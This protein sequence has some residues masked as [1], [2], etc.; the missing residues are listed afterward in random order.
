MFKKALWRFV[1]SYLIIFVVPLLI[2]IGAYFNVKQ[3]ML[4]S[5]YR[6]NKTTLNQLKDKMENEVMKP[7]ESLADWI[8]LNP[9]Y[10]IFLPEANEALD[11]NDRLLNIRNLCREISSQTYKNSYI[12]DAFIYIDSQNLIIGPSYTTTPYNYYTYIYRPLN[13]NYDKWKELL[14]GE[15]QLKYIPS[16]KVKA[17]YKEMQTILFANTLSRWNINGKNAN[18]FVIIDQSKIINLMKE[19]ISYPK[20]IIWILDRDNNQILHVASN[21]EDNI[22]LPPLNFSIYSDFNIKELIIDNEKW[23]VYYIVS[24][25]YGWK[26]ISMVPV[27]NFFEEIR[28]IRNFSLLLLGLMSIV[29]TILIFFFSLQNYRPL[30]EIKNL[31]QSRHTEPTQ[32]NKSEYDVI[33]ELVQITLTKED[34]LKNQ[35]LRFTPI[36]KNNLL[37]QLITGNLTQKEIGEIELRT[38]GLEDPN[39]NFVVAVLEVDDCSGFIKEETEQEYALATFVITNVL[40]ELLANNGIRYWEIFMSKTKMSLIIETSSDEREFILKLSHIFETMIDFLE[41]NFAIYISVGISNIQKGIGNIKSAYEQAEKVLSLKFTKPNLKVFSFIQLHKDVIQQSEFLPKDI[42][43]RLTNSIKEAASEKVE[44]IL[45]E[46]LEYITHLAS[47]HLGKMI[48]VYLY[49]LYYQILNSVPNELSEKLKPQPEEVMKLILEEKNPKKIFSRIKEDFL[50]LTKSVITNR[51]KSGNDL[52]V[53][54]LEFVEKEFANPDISLS[55]IA[56]KFDITPQYLSAIFKEK[57]GQNLSD[58]ILN[59]R[60]N[61]AKELLLT[62]D[63]SVTQIAKSIGYTEVSGFTK[64]FKKFEGVSPNKFREINKA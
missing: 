7:V 9:Y 6:Y 1:F 8:N 39:D 63:Y 22:S 56:E 16:F 37:F 42:E 12:L 31:L 14:N 59:L 24:P 38:L 49:G 64:A 27:N 55:A 17:D 30:S 10:F 21:K 44:R 61:R 40:N 28:R 58:Y 50:N 3:I 46:V 34:E 45:D 57:T 48:F 43:N 23:I 4:L 60:M 11:S 2:G 36:I 5:L 13:L 29:E 62:T 53:S 52:I 54:I 41:K 47:P 35:I 26:Y 15:Y 33:R 19:I 51:Q 18:V 32:K 25:T 20:G